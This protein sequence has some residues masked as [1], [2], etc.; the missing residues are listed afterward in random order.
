MT[1]SET[2]LGKG[3]SILT[4]GVAC[5]SLIPGA[6]VAGSAIDT[7]EDTTAVQSTAPAHPQWGSGTAMAGS[8]TPLIVTASDAVPWG[9]SVIPV[10]HLP[11]V[12]TATQSDADEVV[13]SI[14]EDFTVL[15]KQLLMVLQPTAS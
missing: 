2:V 10:P 7:H 13:P 8:D 4:Q 12:D 14:I 3:Q 9:S 6:A 11:A 15:N 5:K 1:L